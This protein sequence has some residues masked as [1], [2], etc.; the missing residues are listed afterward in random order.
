MVRTLA[1]TC[2]TKGGTRGLAMV[3]IA[4]FVCI[5]LAALLD[6]VAM[7]RHKLAHLEKL[8]RIGNIERSAS[9][10]VAS[11]LFCTLGNLLKITESTDSLG[12]SSV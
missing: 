10:L 4:G 11:L 5:G 12:N 2:L 7:A 9:V 6:T 3:L 8:E 1:G